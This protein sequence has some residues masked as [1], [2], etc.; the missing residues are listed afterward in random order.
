MR[1]AAPRDQANAVAFLCTPAAEMI[2]GQ[3]LRVDGGLTLYA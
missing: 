3:V 1:Y 2:H